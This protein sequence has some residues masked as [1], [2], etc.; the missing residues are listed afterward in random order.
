M[1]GLDEQGVRDALRQA[2]ESLGVG[3]ESGRTGGT[4]RR[5]SEARTAVAG[6]T[7][8][9]DGRVRQ[10]RGG[11]MECEVGSRVKRW[12]W[13]ENRHDDPTEARARAG[14]VLLAW[15]MHIALSART[16]P[17]SYE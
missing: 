14:G 7:V 13:I 6:V 1:A 12:D 10:A 2:R 17:R 16:F 4:P 11:W 9:A 3:Q 8:G 5:P 15:H